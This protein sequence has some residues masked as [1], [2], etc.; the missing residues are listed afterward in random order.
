MNRPASV[1]LT[2][3]RLLAAAAILLVATVVVLAAGVDPT[4]YFTGV[5]FGMVIAGLFAW[6]AMRRQKLQR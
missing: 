4:L 2:R 6:R 1:G 5:A 3:K